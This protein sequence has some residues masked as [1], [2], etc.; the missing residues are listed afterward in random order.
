MPFEIIIDKNGK[1]SVAK[2]FG[3]LTASE[4]L[5]SIKERFSDIDKLKKFK[6]IIADY[7]DV[8]HFDTENADVRDYAEIYLKA[9]AHNK[10][11]IMIGIM[12]TD[13]QF[14]LGRMWE[15]YA[16]GMPWPHQIFRSMGEAR[17]WLKEMKVAD[18]LIK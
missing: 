15:A 5:E 10:D 14:G 17:V 13:L 8:T 11:V 16:Q 3:E 4:I 18:D 7:T 6:I 1:R 9:S 12:P 2:Y